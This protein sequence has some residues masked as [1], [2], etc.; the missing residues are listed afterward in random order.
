MCR[1]H[2]YYS[3]TCSHLSSPT[4]STQ[5]SLI[6]TIFSPLSSPLFRIVCASYSGS[7]QNLPFNNLFKGLTFFSFLKQGSVLAHIPSASHHSWSKNTGSNLLSLVQEHRK[8]SSPARKLEFI[9]SRE[10]PGSVHSR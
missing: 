8:A 2:R 3:L 7:P 5:M 1:W 6:C 4:V 9:Q 10:V